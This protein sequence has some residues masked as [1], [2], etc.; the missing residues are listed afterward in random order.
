MKPHTPKVVLSLKLW[1]PRDE[2]PTVGGNC[3]AATAGLAA[4]GGQRPGVGVVVE[5]GGKD[6]I[7]Q[8]KT[9][10]ACLRECCSRAR[11]FRTAPATTT[12]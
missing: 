10:E 1:D 2:Q 8:N 4:A 5:N 6:T 9:G 12:S 11:R 7:L 3:H